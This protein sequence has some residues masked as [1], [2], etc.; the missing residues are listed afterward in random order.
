M[1]NKLTIL[2][3]TEYTVEYSI[4]IT[5]FS[6]TFLATYFNCR[7]YTEDSFQTIE[8]LDK[9]KMTIFTE[10]WKKHAVSFDIQLILEYDS[11][12]TVMCKR[13]F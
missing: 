3:T 2:Y 12:L 9:S 8:S 5:D 10:H 7:D 11:K 6:K 4:K 1:K 13:I